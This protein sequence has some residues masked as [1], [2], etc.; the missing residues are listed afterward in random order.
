MKPLIQKLSVFGLVCLLIIVVF[1]ALKQKEDIIYL[2]QT[3]HTS[4]IVIEDLNN[5][6]KKQN[7]DKIKYQKLYYEYHKLYFECKKNNSS[8]RKI[9][10]KKNTL[11][12][13]TVEEQIN[14]K[15]RHDLFNVHYSN[16]IF[17]HPLTYLI[18]NNQFYGKIKTIWF[19]K[20][21]E[22]YHI[23]FYNIRH[24]N[25]KWQLKDSDFIS[26]FSFLRD[27][28]KFELRHNRHNVL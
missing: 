19:D 23:S 4:K 15:K 14:T 9:N 25:I 7:L 6:V 8:K 13:P 20:D 18:K 12:H 24:I 3:V 2:N 17:K 21:R 10:F 1:I 27:G 16:N 22:T 11:I 26:L 28:E 5:G